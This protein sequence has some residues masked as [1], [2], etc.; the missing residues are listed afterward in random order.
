MYTLPRG[1]VLTSWTKRLFSS[2][3]GSFCLT[4]QCHNEDE[5]SLTLLCYPVVGLAP[6]ETAVGR[7]QSF[8]W[9]VLC[10]SVFAMLLCHCIFLLLEVSKSLNSE[11]ASP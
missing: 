6:L 7:L 2:K 1:G 10:S 8:L 5:H 11:T 9:K 3:V 4:A